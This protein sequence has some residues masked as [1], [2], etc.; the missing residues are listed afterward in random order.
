MRTGEIASFIDSSIL[1]TESHLVYFDTAC[2]P[3]IPPL[4]LVTINIFKL[5]TCQIKIQLLRDK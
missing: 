5:V 4:H 1:G 3:F 2:D